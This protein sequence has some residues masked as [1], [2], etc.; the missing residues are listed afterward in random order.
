MTS[1]KTLAVYLILGT[2]FTAST[3]ASP[4]PDHGAAMK[5]DLPVLTAAMLT[6]GMDADPYLSSYEAEIAFVSDDENCD[7]DEALDAVAQIENSK[8]GYD[9][10][11]LRQ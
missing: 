1:L 6:V 8:P 7:E 5:S 10:P 4:E 3:F 2:A 9:A 11:S